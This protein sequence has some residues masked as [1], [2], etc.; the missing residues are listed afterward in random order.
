MLEKETPTGLKGLFC[1][2][3][4]RFHL[5]DFFLV[6][7][8]RLHLERIQYSPLLVALSSWGFTWRSKHDACIADSGRFHLHWRGTA[9]DDL[10]RRNHRL[11][12]ASCV[13]SCLR[14]K[15]QRKEPGMA[16]EGAL[17]AHIRDFAEQAIGRGLAQFAG[18]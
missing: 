16:L 14:A 5:V 3:P 7:Q 11:P 17:R 6:G 18:D 15:H 10:G 1:G 13:M 12:V 2:W 9:W 4:A 8:P